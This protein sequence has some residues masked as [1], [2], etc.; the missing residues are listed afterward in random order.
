MPGLTERPGVQPD[1]TVRLPPLPR[2]KSL[3]AEDEAALQQW[4]RETRRILE[5]NINDKKLSGGS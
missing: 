5:P 1:Q 2:L 4:W 3:A